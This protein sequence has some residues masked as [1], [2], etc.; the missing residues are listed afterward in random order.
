MLLIRS[1]SVHQF[2]SSLCLVMYGACAS[3]CLFDTIH[4]ISSH[5]RLGRPSVFWGLGGK[6]AMSGHFAWGNWLG[7]GWDMGH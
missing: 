2:V 6:L 5:L 7:L 4:Y 1:V 3:Y